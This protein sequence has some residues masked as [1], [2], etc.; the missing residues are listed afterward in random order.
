MAAS[1]FQHLTL[2]ERRSLFRFRDPDASRDSQRNMSVYYPVSRQKL[3]LGRRR[4]AEN[5]WLNRV[6]PRDKG[7]L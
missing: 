7:A 6:A 2:D 1:G 5:G 4:A 3:A